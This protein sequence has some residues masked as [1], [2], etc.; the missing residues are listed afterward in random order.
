MSHRLIAVLLG[1]TLALPAAAQPVEQGPKNVPEFQ[2]AFENQTRAPAIQ[3]ATPVDIASV[4]SGL[5]HPW[6]IEVMPEID[7]P[8]HVFALL[9]AIPDLADPDEP[10]DSYRSVQGY[11][12]NALNPA[13]ERTYEVVARLLD[14]LCEM[15][16][17]PVLHIGGDEVD[18]RAWQASPEAVA[19]AERIGAEDAMGLQSHFL[20]RVQEMVRDR[21]RIMGG[22]DECALGGGIVPDRTVLLAWQS[23][24]TT[25]RL[26]ADG[27][28][29]VA[30]PGQAYYLDMVQGD[31]WDAFG[32]SWA[33][34]VPPRKTYDHEAAE[35]LPDGPGRLIGVQ[36]AIWTE[37]MR[38]LRQ[39]NHMVFPRLAAVAEAAWSPA[40]AK[41]WP[42]FAALSRL[43]PQL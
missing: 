21:G 10:A 23:I 34:P 17:G 3:S 41:D 18:P 14:E 33:G 9:A 38:D 42:R 31:G 16:P 20:R 24:E 39:L 19:L 29:V 12:N 36:A 4:A 6:G 25:S 27:Y 30:T 1:S 35:G 22:W 2:P 7:M 32:T 40:H 15:F 28:D 26:I 11:S 13:R 5:D 37:H 8:G 43:M